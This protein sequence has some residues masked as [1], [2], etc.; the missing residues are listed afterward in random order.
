LIFIK[1]TNLNLFEFTSNKNIM[2]N[3]PERISKKNGLNDEL[4]KKRVENKPK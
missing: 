3:I 1:F 4:F 2:N